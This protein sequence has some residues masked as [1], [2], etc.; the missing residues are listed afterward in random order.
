MPAV[1]ESAIV[2]T[3]SDIDGQGHA[4]NLV[5]L[6]WMQDAAVAHSDAQGWPG[7]RYRELGVGWVVR[8]HAIE[9]LQPAYAG[10]DVVVRTWVADMK[11][12]TSLR[13]YQIVRRGDDALLAEAFTNWVFVN[14]R[15]GFPKRIP[16]EV[17]SAFEVIADAAEDA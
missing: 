12:A 13:R 6:R 4:N 3:E 11:K 2:V 10:D 7:E 16:G 1:F 14:F 5:Y 17:S 9:Y 15:T 8:S